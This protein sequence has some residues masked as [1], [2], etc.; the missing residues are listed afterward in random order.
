MSVCVY[1]R[2]CLPHGW[3]DQAGFGM[4]ASFDLFH[5]LSYKEIRVL[6]NS[7]IRVLHSGTLFQTLD[8]VNFVATEKNVYYPPL[9]PSS[10]VVV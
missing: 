1:H 8:L 7:K 5:T 3:M 10:L 6:K 9:A 4:E 2:L